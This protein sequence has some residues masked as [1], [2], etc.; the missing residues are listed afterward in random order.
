L[1]SIV[2]IT[3]LPGV[4]VA[5]SVGAVCAIAP[6]LGINA[7]AS[8]VIAIHQPMLRATTVAFFEFVAGRSRRQSSRD[9]R[10]L[11]IGNRLGRA[12]SRMPVD[13]KLFTRS[14]QPCGY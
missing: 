7:P 9:P 10:S 11:Q 2:I 14:R 13:V 1:S 6:E 3:A 4:N 5:F 8:A 12:A